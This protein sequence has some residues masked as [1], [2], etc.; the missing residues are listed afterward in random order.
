MNGPIRAI[1]EM[2]CGRRDEGGKEFGD[3]HAPVIPGLGTE[4]MVGKDPNEDVLTTEV[5]ASALLVE[6]G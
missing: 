6:G 5:L 4:T 2:K 1:E 3:C